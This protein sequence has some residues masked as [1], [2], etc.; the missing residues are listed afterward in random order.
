M[1]HI[2]QIVKSLEESGL[3]IRDVSEASKIDM[4]LGTLYK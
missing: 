1:N 3:S 2:M 4:V